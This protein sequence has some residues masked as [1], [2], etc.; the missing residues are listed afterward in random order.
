MRRGTSI[1]AGYPDR[2]GVVTEKGSS[3]GIKAITIC[4]DYDD[5]LRLTLP[6]TLQ[7]VDKFLIVTSN[8]DTRTQQLA[9][10]YGVD[11]FTTDAFYEDGA[12]FNKGRAMEQGFDV[13][14]RDGW[15][16]ILD[17][18]IVL[19]K[20]LPPLDLQIG[21]MY[22]PRR[23]I[24]SNVDGMSSLPDI[25]DV[26]IPIRVE[27]GNFG[28]FQLFHADDPAVRTRRPWYQTDWIHAGGAD[29]VFEKFWRP[30]NKSG[31]PFEVIHLGDPDQ[32]WFGRVRP[33][34]DTGE[35][36]DEAGVRQQFQTLLHSKYGWKGHQKTG[37]QVVERIGGSAAPEDCHNHEGHRK[38]HEVI[39]VKR[40]STPQP[41]APAAKPPANIPGTPP[42]IPALR[43]L[44]PPPPPRRK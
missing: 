29:S 6:R 18:D 2:S 26:Q 43:E 24:L 9:A 33:R 25:P 21:K 27:H 17:A 31:L 16:L 44:P 23:R 39:T 37:A 7:H 34:I 40:G 30:Q 20:Q 4:V 14:G 10:E 19:P 22:T 36:A 15:I 41:P 35:V 8:A 12:A 1:K 38:K 32:N 13:L 28:Y 3:M 42:K 11:C 5:F